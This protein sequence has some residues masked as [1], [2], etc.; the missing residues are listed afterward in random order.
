M[1]KERIEGITPNRIKQDL[2]LCAAGSRL[3][4][5]QNAETMS[6]FNE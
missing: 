4:N 3:V 6:I 1:G 5:A 2:I